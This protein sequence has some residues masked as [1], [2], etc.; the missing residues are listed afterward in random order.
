MCVEELKSVQWK[1]SFENRLRFDKITESLKVRWELFKTQCKSKIRLENV[2]INY[3]LPLEA[4]RRDT[5]TNLKWFGASDTRHLGLIQWL[6]LHLLC[7]ATLFGYHQRHIFPPWLGS[8]CECNAWKYNAEF[9]KGGWEL[10]S[11]FNP[12]V[13]QS[14]RN[15]QTMMMMMKLPILPS[16]EKL[17]LV[18][19]TA[20]KT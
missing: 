3:V 13:D 16:A 12:F 7:G 10:W 19:S 1:C 15:C 18:L 11:Y 4:A 20:P 5:I 8:V 2:A 9:T 17:E 6:H 14:S